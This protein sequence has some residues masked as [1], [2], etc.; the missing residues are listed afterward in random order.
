MSRRTE[1]SPVTLSN[2]MTPLLSPDWPLAELSRFEDATLNASAPPQQRWLDGWQLRLSP[3]KARRARSVHGL[4]RGLMPLDDR[5]A[6][7]AAAYREAGLPLIF[8]ITPFT[9][10]RDL[11]AALAQRGFVVADPTVVMACARL[12]SEPGDAPAGAV[13]AR[14][15][16][17]EFA[18]ALGM[19]RGSPAAH[20]HSQAERL[21][22]SP[23]PYQGWLLRRQD[24]GAVL[25][26]AQTAREGDFV[27]LYDVFVARDQRGQGVSRWLC[28]ALLARARAEGA[29]LGYLQVQADN[30]PAIGV[31][32]R[33]GFTDGYSYHYRGLPGQ[34]A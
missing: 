32:R 33:L 15:D 25:A 19:L 22:Q 5:L 26:C 14:P 27:G 29:R 1:T 20:R 4:A 9:Q 10:P 17:T 7:C 16:H 2:P 24:D 18:E 21:K 28:A 30:L 8:R 23:A 11:D 3:G 31:Y 34:T 6:A 13:L 12:P